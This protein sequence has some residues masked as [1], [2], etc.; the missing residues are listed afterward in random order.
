[1]RFHDTDE[2]SDASH[3]TQ[4]P[5]LRYAS[6][7]SVPVAWQTP[8]DAEST[9]SSHAHPTRLP[10][11]C[12]CA[13]RT[14]APHP[15]QLDGGWSGRGPGRHSCSAEGTPPLHWPTAPERRSTTTRWPTF[16]AQM[17]TPAPRSTV[18]PSLAFSSCAQLLSMS[19]RWSSLMLKRTQL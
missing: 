19:V 17:S 6:H 5:R 2:R 1:T 15:P 4:A 12:C 8:R 7:R 11:G 10:S 18:S 16:S 14:P 9:A 13:F 3:K